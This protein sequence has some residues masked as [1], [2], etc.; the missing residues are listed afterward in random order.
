MPEDS[1]LRYLEMVRTLA[2]HGLERRRDLRICPHPQRMLTLHLPEGSHQVADISTGGLSFYSSTR[3]PPDFWLLGRLDLPGRH[4]PLE[5]SLLVV[6][7]KTEGL[8]RCRFAEELQDEA[9]NSIR[10]YI[11][12]RLSEI[13]QA[14]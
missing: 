5:V 7:C 9:G 12:Q 1:Y 13:E 6:D 14:A 2:E 11:Q 8:V 10:E 3:F 4:S